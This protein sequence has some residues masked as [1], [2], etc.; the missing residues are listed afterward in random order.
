MRL[1]FGRTAGMVTRPGRSYLSQQNS[2]PVPERCV[3]KLA[4]VAEYC[5]SAGH[6]REYLRHFRE[7]CIWRINGR[8]GGRCMEPEVTERSFSAQEYS[9]LQRYEIPPIPARLLSI[10]SQSKVTCTPVGSPFAYFPGGVSNPLSHRR[11]YPFG[12][13]D[14]MALG[15]ALRPSFEENTRRRAARCQG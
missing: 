15:I 11:S 10:E 6:L 8:N 3:I 2:L 13:A 1:G 4:R 5:W 12:T 14:A 9:N 7:D